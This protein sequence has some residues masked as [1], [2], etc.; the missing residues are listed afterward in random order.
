MYEFRFKVSSY[1]PEGNH[2]MD[3]E[4]PLYINKQEVQME[5]AA[6]E[7]WRMGKECCFDKLYSQM[8][9]NLARW[10]TENESLDT[11]LRSKPND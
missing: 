11:V 10:P 4:A 5:G 8:C 7:A 1:D 9:A 3:F 2:L 6:I